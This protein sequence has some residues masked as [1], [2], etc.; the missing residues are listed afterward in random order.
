MKNYKIQYIERNIHTLYVPANS[1]KEAL[2]FIK[3]RL[4]YDLEDFEY[5]SDSYQVREISLLKKLPINLKDE[6]TYNWWKG[7]NK[8]RKRWLKKTK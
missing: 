6:N 1:K 2:Q 8:S 5:N 4:H 7:V 3:D